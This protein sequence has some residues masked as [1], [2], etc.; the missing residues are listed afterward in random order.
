VHV[1]ELVAA[2][3]D[4]V[5]AFDPADYRGAIAL[6]GDGASP[7]YL[8]GNSRGLWDRFVAAMDADRELAA[9]GHPLDRYVEAAIDGALDPGDVVRYAHRAEPDFLPMIDVA[10]AAGLKIGACGLAIHP[11]YGP[12]IALRAVVVAPT[13]PASREPRPLATCDCAVHCAPPSDAARDS[14][15]WQPEIW[16]TA[17]DA[18]PIGRAHRYGDAQL[19]YHYHR[20]RAALY[21][22]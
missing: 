5:L 20:D 6:P 10:R 17:R 13:T 22:R 15:G 1:G 2:G 18:C 4:V 16:L 21:D 8:I 11:V 19:R 9:S 3:L 7:A 12:W 14:V